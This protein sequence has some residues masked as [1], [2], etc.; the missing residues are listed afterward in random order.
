[1]LVALVGVAQGTQERLA[2]GNTGKTKIY[3]VKVTL[4]KE[5]LHLRVKD[6]MVKPH[7]RLVLVG[8]MRYR[9]STS[10]LSTR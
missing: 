8:S 2:H 6:N 7:G 4:H 9:T 10:S 3:F 1:M 5:Y